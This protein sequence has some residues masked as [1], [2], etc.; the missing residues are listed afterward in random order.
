VAGL[1]ARLQAQ[2]GALG[3]CSALRAAL[4]E[5]ERRAAARVEEIVAGLPQAQRDHV[6]GYLWR[7]LEV[8]EGLEAA[9]EAAL[10]AHSGAVLFSSAPSALAFLEALRGSEVGR[11][12]ALVVGPKPVSASFGFVPLGRPLAPR[13]RA[14]QALQPLV[15]RLLRDVY[16]V[17]DLREA[18]DRY[19]ASDPPA[20]FVTAAGERLDPSGAMTGGRAGADGAIRRAGELRR[21]SAEQEALA[22]QV[23]ELEAAAAAAGERV[24]AAAADVDRAR[25]RQHERELAAVDLGKDLERARERLEVGGR[26]V[27]RL[28]EERAAL[29]ASQERL[30]REWA[31][32]AGRCE[33]AERERG[34]LEAEAAALGADVDSR[35]A[36]TDVLE[37]ALGEARVA[38]A[39]LRARRDE[40]RAAL[41]RLAGE[42]EQHRSWIAQRRQEVESA[43]VRAAEL[44]ASSEAAEREMGERIEREIHARQEQEAMREG[45]EAGS[46]RIEA[47]EQGARETARERSD[48][49]QSLASREL[50]LQELRLRQDQQRER[51]RERYA[52]DIASYEVPEAVEEY[53]DPEERE[54]ELKRLRS[55]LES[56]GSVHLG[57]IEEYEGVSERHRYLAEQKKDLELSVERLENAIARINRTSRARFRET[58]EAVN[59]CFQ[60]LFPRMFR[61]G[62]AEL[63]LTDSEDVLEAGIEIHAQPPGKRL[64]TVNLLSGGEKSLTALALLMAVFTVKPSPFFLLD[65]VDAALDDANVGRFDALLREM[66]GTAQFLVITHNQ[67]SIESA[68]T[69]FGVTMEQ[70]GRSK[71]VSVNLEERAPE[72]AA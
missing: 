15:E 11:A 2:R 54:A 9:L 24:A 68:D 13:V 53:G 70:P 23:R 16:L 67:S 72:P 1:E 57:A 56:L 36:D 20:C 46:A 63:M 30:S 3:E 47:L 40:Q 8:D 52:V 43:R 65:E 29:S 62:R 14:P 10:G 39:E 50:Q 41:Q 69:L 34:A 19:G 5:Q 38:L 12:S 17:D 71:L 51:M 42:V 49:Q 7:L 44:R 28:Q 21:R 61:G 22:A 55:A 45:F 27:A 66:A 48:Q 6:Q 31:E 59:T 18:I 26:Q 25:E 58:F 64:Q 32:T 37:R 35:A 60:D 4:E 33:V